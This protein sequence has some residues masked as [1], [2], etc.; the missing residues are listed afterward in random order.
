MRPI[1]K[2]PPATALDLLPPEPSL[3]QELR[4]LPRPYWALFC[5]IF[6]NR[7]GTF[8]YPFLTILL[9]RR[10][11]ANWEIG[12]ALG[13]YGLGGLL[14][15]LCGGWFADRFGR[16]HTIITGTALNAVCVLSMAGVQGLPALL[17]LTTLTGFSV[18]FF[19]PAASALVADVVPERLRLRAYAGTRMAGNAGFACGTAAGGLLINYAPFWLFAGDALTTAA[20]GVMAAILLPEGVRASRREARW[21]EAFVVL[22]QDRRFW[23][24]FAAQVCIAFIF[25]QFSTTYSK[26]ILQR[27]MAVTFLGYALS[28][29]QVFGFLVGW[30][31]AMVVGLEVLLTRFVQRF[32]PRYVMTLGNA[33]IGLGFASNAVAD[34]LG[35]LF[36]GMTLFTFGEMLSLP[37]TSTAVADLAPEKMRGRYLG[38]LSLSW[39]VANLIAP[40]V[41]FAL[42]GWKPMVL[43]IG[44]GTL[45]ITAAV[46]QWKGAGAEPNSRNFPSGKAAK[47]S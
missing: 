18:G 29:E 47:S 27:K 5:G 16:K 10:G 44:C 34:G 14:A 43:W 35:Q 15:T 7:F 38:M 31:G 45:G 3:W 40:Q 24:L 33:L 26:E 30:N 6:I 25:A 2:P 28:P 19:G 21:S 32:D 36:A 8:V 37:L 20:Y 4:A 11:F 22:R 1:V 23:S 41:G 13:G 39:A 9:T 12:V 17:M 42:F 46:I